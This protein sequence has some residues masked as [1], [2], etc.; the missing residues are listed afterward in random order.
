MRKYI[1]CT[2]ALTCILALAGCNN[3]SMNYIIENEPSIV[4]IVEEVR[5]NSILIYIETDG[6]SLRRR[7]QRFFGCGEHG[8]LYGF[9]CR[10]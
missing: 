4:G 9:V 6:L 10:G 1:V 3:R 5:D 7:V 2:L 8:Q